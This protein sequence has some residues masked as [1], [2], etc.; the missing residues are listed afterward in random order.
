[1]KSGF[2]DLLLMHP[3]FASVTKQAK[4]ILKKG[5][6]G[7]IAV[8]VGPPGSG[9]T[10]VCRH[11]FASGMRQGEPEWQGNGFQFGVFTSN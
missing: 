3:N 10:V 4:E 11:L 1:M 2:D 7:Q 8:I 6:D 9:K 5:N